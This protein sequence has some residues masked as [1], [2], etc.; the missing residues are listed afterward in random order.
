MCPLLAQD[1]IGSLIS[2]SVQEKI[3]VA[4]RQPPSARTW[5]DCRRSTARDGAER[6]WPARLFFRRL[7]LLVSFSF[8]LNL[9]ADGSTG[10]HPWMVLFISIQR[11]KQP[12]PAD[13][14]RGDIRPKGAEPRPALFNAW[15]ACQRGAPWL[16]SQP[17]SSRVASIRPFK[18]NRVSGDPIHCVWPCR[19]LHRS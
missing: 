5:T 9:L 15:E 11:G 3:S 12:G 6:P 2:V 13:T 10:R 18:P 16:P 8:S 19:W 14:G 4:A 7:H 17:L 1:G